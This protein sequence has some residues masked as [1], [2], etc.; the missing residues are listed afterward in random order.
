LC[1][2]QCARATRDYGRIRG[3]AHSCARVHGC[4]RVRRETTLTLLVD[5][6]GNECGAVL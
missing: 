2:V 5:L 3:L 6:S 4:W 1:C